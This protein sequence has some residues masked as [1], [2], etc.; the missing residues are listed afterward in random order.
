LASP[1]PTQTVLGLFSSI[2]TAPIEYVPSFWKMGVKVMPPFVV[3]H[4]P[5]DATPT[6]QVCLSSG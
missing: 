5:P 6:Y 1:L 2:T 3:F 4:T